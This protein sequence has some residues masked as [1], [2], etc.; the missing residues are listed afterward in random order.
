MK[1][2]LSILLVFGMIFPV[3]ASKIL[4]LVDE[5]PIT[6]FDVD[7]RILMMQTLSGSNHLSLSKTEILNI[8]I[9]EKIKTK[10]AERL[11]IDVTDEEIKN[12]IAYLERQNGLESGS[13]EKIFKEK[14]MDI[15]LLENQAKADLS[16]LKILQTM[17]EERPTV[18]S[19]EV[20]AKLEEIKKE[21]VKPRYLLAEI[22]LP[23]GKDKAKVLGKMQDLFNRIVSGESFPGL[24]FENSKGKT[25]AQGGDLG[26]VTEDVLPADILPTVQQLDVGQLSKP[27]EGKDGVYIVLMRD[28]QRALT[29]TDVEAWNVTQM[30][31]DK[32]QTAKLSKEIENVSDSCMKFEAFSQKYGM[33]GSQN[34]GYIPV[35][36]MPQ[37]FLQLLKDIPDNKLVGPVPAPDFDLF[38]MKCGQKV[39]SVLPD[40]ELIRTELEAVKMEDMSKEMFKTVRENYLIEMKD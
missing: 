9:D 36:R 3:H 27:I 33:Q 2:I 40:K 30:L 7:E 8:L 31:L 38:L 39:M 26:W 29:S 1:L 10:E 13:F 11:A 24:A 23:Y 32:S 6:D 15:S 34:M 25:A 21:I 12:G 19:A 5:D 28:K 4:A 37:H 17:M 20:D 22:Y 16:W 18:S 35:V 14:S